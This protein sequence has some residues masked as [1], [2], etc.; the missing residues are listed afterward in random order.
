MAYTESASADRTALYFSKE[1]VWG[2]TPT[3]PVWTPYRYT[4][5]SVSEE[6]TYAESQEIRSDRMTS[7]TSLVDS[8]P[9]GG[10]NIE[11]SYGSFDELI[12][13]A[14]MSSFGTDLTS[15]LAGI[16]LDLTTGGTAQL[17]DSAATG[18]FAAL[19]VGQWLRIDGATNPEND[20]YYQVQ[21]VN[22]D[23]VTVTPDITTS[24][25]G[26]AATVSGSM[27]RN[28]TTRQSF[29]LL[30]DLEDSSDSSRHLFT[31]QRVSQMALSMSTSSLL[32][33]SFTFMGA[34]ATLSGSTIPGETFANR[35]TSD[36]MNC[37]S[38][39]KNMM[40]DHTTTDVDGSYLSVDL[41]V[42][43]NMRE[44]KA[45]GVLGNR[46]I[47]AGKFGVT[48]SGTQ[49]FIS[50]AQALKFKNGQ[51]FSFS[52]VMEDRDGNAYLVSLPNLKY[53]SFTFNAGQEN[54]DLNAN[55]EAM[56]LADPV[57]GC[58]MQIDKFDAAP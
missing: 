10:V 52:Y 35:S 23:D 11:M 54:S 49:Y 1:S 9:G 36:I 47:K 38:S 57:T 5:E 58:A 41:S 45:V 19:E 48:L 2:V 43:N 15:T 26:S 20:G 53:S 33:G 4:G 21:S 13:A 44:Q 17:S 51:S 27:I 12:E 32:T 25:V 30:K 28:G 8:S 39:I 22:T 37:V 24:E 56:A 7:D 42:N 31:G 29:S 34:A 50:R 40:Q 55:T 18:A 3:S 6:L 16:T 14:M 46:G